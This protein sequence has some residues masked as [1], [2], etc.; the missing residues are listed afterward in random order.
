MKLKLILFF[1]FLANFANS[2]SKIIEISEN[3][4]LN[5]VGSYAGIW[6]D[7]TSKANINVAVKQQYLPVTKPFVNKGLSESA[8]CATI[9]GINI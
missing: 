5:L 8:Y 3:T 4:P 1:L 9:I 2:Q 7:T 6:E